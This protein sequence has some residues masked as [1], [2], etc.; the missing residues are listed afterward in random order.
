L[1]SKATPPVSGIPA[2]APPISAKPADHT[3]EGTSG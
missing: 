1:A 3:A 2:A